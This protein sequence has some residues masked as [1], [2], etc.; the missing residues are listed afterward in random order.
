MLHWRQ[1]EYVC[2]EL[3][4]WKKELSHFDNSHLIFDIYNADVY[5]QGSDLHFL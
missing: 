5:S 1:Q 3:I 2:V 4:F